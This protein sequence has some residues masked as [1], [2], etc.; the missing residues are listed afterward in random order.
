MSFHRDFTPADDGPV[1][2]DVLKSMLQYA[3]SGFAR[4]YIQ[5][6]H[7]RANDPT[8]EDAARV[9]AVTAVLD[10]LAHE[11]W[12]SGQPYALAPE[13]TATLA[14]AARALDLTGRVVDSDSA[15]S[16][17]GVLVLP[18]PIYQRDA[19]GH[20]TSIGAIAWAPYRVTETG[21]TGWW[22][23]GWANRDALNDP[24]AVRRREQLADAPTI[25]AQLGP[26]ILSSLADLPADTPLI[27]LAEAPSQADHAQESAPPGYHCLDDPTMRQRAITVLLYA[28][29]N[30]QG[31]P[32]TNPLRQDSDPTQHLNAHQAGLPNNSP[33]ARRPAEPVVSL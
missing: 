28:Y 1:V 19:L 33:T 5:A 7:A 23:T 30:L 32:A 20:V 25:V 15:P 24:A 29:W 10:R 13:L 22:V 11:P 2:P 26:Y 17:A 27:A 31:Q 21:R 12:R 3:S 8:S 18:E 14:T 9:A 4:Q 16:D 6:F